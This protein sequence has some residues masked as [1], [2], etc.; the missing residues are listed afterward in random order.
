MLLVFSSFEAVFLESFTKTYNA[1]ILT[2]L[3]CA[4]PAAMLLTISLMGISTI[5]D[6]SRDHLIADPDNL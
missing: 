5:R 2:P 3:K 1:T 4:T 6:G